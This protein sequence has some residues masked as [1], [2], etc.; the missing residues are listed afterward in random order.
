MSL[1]SSPVTFKAGT[2]IYSLHLLSSAGWG[3]RRQRRGDVS[4]PTTAQESVGALRVQ[5]QQ[6]LRAGVWCS[7]NPTWAEVS[8]TDWK[9]QDGGAEACTA[10]GEVP[11]DGTAVSRASS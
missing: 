4:G 10:T 7:R 11:G 2:R 3:L 9:Q 6:V 8:R 1:L 5:G